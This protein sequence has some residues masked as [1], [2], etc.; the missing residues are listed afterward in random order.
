M[1]ETL[2]V[3]QMLANSFE[4]KRKFRWL[5]QIDGIDAYTLKTAT[6]PSLTFDETVID[7]INTK[8]Y[9][10]GKQTWNT[11]SITLH[12][13]IAPSAAQNVMNW[14]R[15]AYEPLTGR[16]GYA[17][18]YKRNIALK[19]LDPQGTVVEL[20]DIIGAWVQDANWGD[21]DY[22]SSDAVEVS[23]TIRYDNSILQF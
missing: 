21:L 5:L 18:Q 20:W 13:P 14:V 15:T 19:L 10:A 17:D 9:L 7:Y 2:E 11:I 12:D 1:A 22:A 4:P 8:R 3:N 6:R 23:L 16:S